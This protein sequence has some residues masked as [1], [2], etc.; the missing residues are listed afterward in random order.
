VRCADGVR[1]PLKLARNLERRIDEDNPAPLLR[2]QQRFQRHTTVEPYHRCLTIAME[3]LGKRI[4][5]LGVQ[6]IHHQHVIIAHQAPR[7]ER[8]AGIAH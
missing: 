6:L 7:N 5:V 2:R 4:R 1:Q 3:Q 8:A